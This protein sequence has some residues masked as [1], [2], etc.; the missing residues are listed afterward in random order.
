MN[1]GSSGKEGDRRG[2]GRLRAWKRRAVV[3]VALLLA[4]FA[5]RLAAVYRFSGACPD[6]AGGRP[7]V[8]FRSDAA[9]ALSP[10]RLTVLSYNI[11]GHATL[12]DGH[13]LEEIAAV[14][15]G[16]G[17]D[18]VALQEVN[19]GRWMSRFEDQA[20]ELA[21]LTGLELAFGASFRE[22]GGELGNAVLTRGRIVAARVYPLPSFGEPRSA[23][24][25]DVDLGGRRVTAF[26]SHLTSWGGV[27]ARERRS[28]VEC[29]ATL[30]RSTPYPYL[31][32]G[33]LNARPEAGELAPLLG[34]RTL[35]FC[36]EPAEET[37]PGLRCRL[38]YI[39]V[40]ARWQVLGSRVLREGPSDH[41]PVAATLELR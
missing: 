37:Y 14:I 18:L 16:A 10:G 12:L 36:G 3:L 22:L 20:R 6:P 13:H 25:C 26:V 28:Q 35:L 2:P 23:L 32:L 4:P 11:E 9:G 34:L 30:L 7:A 27:A 33:D 38:D 39:L 17:A 8:L 5:Y 24:R 15:R 1:E 29:L 21:R 31:L 19:R 41:W 40:D